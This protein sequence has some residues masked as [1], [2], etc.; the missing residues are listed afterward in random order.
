LKIS[1]LL[2]GLLFVVVAAGAATASSELN[3]ADNVAKA[4]QGSKTVKDATALPPG[5]PDSIPADNQLINKGKVLEVIDSDM[6]TYVQVSS[7]QG[8]LWLAVYKT[9]ITKGASVKYSGGIAMRNF[10][11]KALNRTF[12]LIVLV[13]TLEQVGK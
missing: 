8:P 13:D 2:L 3:L 10:E 7:E 6:Y 12:E 9:E 1:V 4:P 5:H 11:S